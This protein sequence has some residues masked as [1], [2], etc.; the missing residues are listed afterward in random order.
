MK[1]T[2]YK[3]WFVGIMAG[4][5]LMVSACSDAVDP[6]FYVSVDRD[7]EIPANL[8]TV[9]THF[10]QLKNVPVL[11]DQNIAQYNLSSDAIVSVNPADAS[12][13]TTFGNID[14]TFVETVEILAVSRLSGG[15]TRMFYSNQPDFTN[16]E[17]ITM[18]NH[19]TDVK[20]VMSEGLI[21]LEVRIKTRAFVPGNINA[22]LTFSYAVFDE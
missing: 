14:W 4:L 10:F 8:N 20:Q 19:F 11:F 21:D 17:E 15:K 6:L 16:R 3:A 12:L 22:T 18:F 1:R 5:T 7:F 13:T 9:E 2:N